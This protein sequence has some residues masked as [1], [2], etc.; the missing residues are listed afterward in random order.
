MSNKKKYMRGAVL[1]NSG[2]PLKIMDNIEIPELQK[3]QVLVKNAY[4]GICRSQL[5]EVRGLRGDDKFLPHLSGHEGCGQVIEVGQ[6]V[7]KVK[8]GDW[9]ILGWI[10]SSGLDVPGP[11]Y[12]CG[13]TIINSGPVTTFSEFSIVSENRIVNLPEGVPKDIGVLFGCALPTG[14]GLV[15]NEIHPKKKS[16]M[17]IVGLGGVGLSALMSIKTLDCDPVIAIDI[18]NDKLDMARRFGATHTINSSENDVISVVMDITKGKGVDHSIEAA[19]HTATIELAFEILNKSSGQC[20][21]ASHP[22]EGDKISLNPH[23]LISGRSIKGSWGGE[24]KPDV[25]IPKLAKFYKKGLLPL[26]TLVKKKYSLDEINQA[27]DDL[28]NFKVYRPIISF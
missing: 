9:V 12:K 28:E 21:F 22:P 4:S 6:S 14:A 26:E 27:L 24:S 15:L 5:M 17:A 18:S 19:G 16:S 23:H 8:K 2:E 1:F 11:T 10:K 20:V 13:D 25:D 3:G 7:R